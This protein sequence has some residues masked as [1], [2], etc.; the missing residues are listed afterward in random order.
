MA[1]SAEKFKLEEDINEEDNANNEEDDDKEEDYRDDDY[2]TN[3]C[4]SNSNNNNH[5]HNNNNNNNNESK[6]YILAICLANGNVVLLKSFDDVSPITISTG[7][8]SPL[9]ADWSNS[10]KLLAIAGTKEEDYSISSQTNGFFQY[11]NL[12]KF[13]SDSGVLIYTINVPF[14]QASW[15][16]FISILK[17]RGY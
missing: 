12:L 5:N 17:N 13:Y 10:R 2:D 3:H 11:E 15:V 6:S 8:R 4:S 16:A 7:L 14:S 9:Q 1:W